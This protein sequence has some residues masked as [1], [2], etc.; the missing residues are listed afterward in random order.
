MTVRHCVTNWRPDQPI[1]NTLRRVYCI[2][3]NAGGHAGS[4]RVAD[5]ACRDRVLERVKRL[6]VVARIHHHGKRRLP[7]RVLR[8]RRI[9]SGRVL[10]IGSSRVAESCC[11]RLWVLSGR[12]RERLRAAWVEVRGIVGG[13]ALRR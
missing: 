10:R 1:T 9:G 5:T 2:I 3:G 8:V 12:M 6:L 11:R 4:G 13:C 7:S